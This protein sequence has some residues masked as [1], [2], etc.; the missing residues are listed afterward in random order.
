M[1][2]LAPFDLHMAIQGADVVTKDGERVR[3]ARYNRHA[4]FHSKILGWVG[5]DNAVCAWDERGRHLYED[6]LQLFIA[7]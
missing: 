4:T 5:E 1:I 3:I 2:M 7:Q 6:G